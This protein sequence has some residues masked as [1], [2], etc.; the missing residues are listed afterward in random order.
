VCGGG[1][2]S[3]IATD[4]GD[5]NAAY[6]LTRGHGI[7]P[8]IL[9]WSS[10]SR[11]GRVQLESSQLIVPAASESESWMH[12]LTNNHGEQDGKYTPEGSEKSGGVTIWGEEVTTI[13]KGFDVNSRYVGFK[14]A[15]NAR[16]DSRPPTDPR[17]SRVCPGPHCHGR[18]DR[19]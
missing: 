18:R 2:L 17:W 6:M 9:V 19:R 1:V 16:L 4:H 3:V 11:S 14:L 15:R 7:K 5:E 13:H 12:G 8:H 10:W